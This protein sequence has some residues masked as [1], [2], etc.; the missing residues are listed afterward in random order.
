MDVPSLFG[1]VGIV[2]TIKFLEFVTKINSAKIPVSYFLLL[3]LH[4]ESACSRNS[5]SNFYDSVGPLVKI[6]VDPLSTRQEK[7][8]LITRR[9]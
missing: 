8:T 1:D 9:V 7:L 5:C 2:D 6:P 4:H 3:Y